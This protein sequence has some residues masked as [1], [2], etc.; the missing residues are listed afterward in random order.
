M[1]LI[2]KAILEVMGEVKGIEKNSNV[3]SGNYGYKGVKDKDVR[4][5]IG[6]SMKKH[7]LSILPIGI[8][9]DRQID[10][11]EE[12]YN[13]QTKTKQSVFTSVITKYLL[14]H[15]SGESIELSGYGHGVDTQDKGAGK[16]TTYAL[17]NTLL[18]TFLVPTGTIEDTDET[19]SEDIDV[20]Q[21][22]PKAPPKVLPNM[23]A[24]QEEKA[25]EW[26]RSQK[27]LDSSIRSLKRKYSFDEVA[28]QI[29]LN[30]E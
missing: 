25:I 13:G 17:K 15:D 3:G 4:L 24:I 16:A 12:T 27:D 18:N 28:L 8:T 5:I 19:H 9:E 10:R 30:K 29:K 26:I 23:T 14:L 7:G 6:A 1:K 20:P 22:A 11:W 2:A 21:A